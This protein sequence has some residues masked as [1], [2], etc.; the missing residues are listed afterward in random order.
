MSEHDKSAEADYSPLGGLTGMRE[1]NKSLDI[2]PK[3]D[4][5]GRA[6]TTRRLLLKLWVM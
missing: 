2:R 6:L 5:R 1:G 4:G 3:P